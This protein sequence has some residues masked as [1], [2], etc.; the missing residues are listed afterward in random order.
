MIWV[1][2]WLCLFSVHCLYSFLLSAHHNHYCYCCCFCSTVTN[3]V[4]RMAVY[5]LKIFSYSLNRRILLC[6]LQFHHFFPYPN[7]AILDKTFSLFVIWQ[8]S[9]NWPRSIVLIWLNKWM[10]IK[11]LHELLPWKPPPAA[12]LQ[13]Q[14]G[15]Q[16]RR[17]PPTKKTIS[18]CARWHALS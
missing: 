12:Q 10:I 16:L 8:P 17:R 14:S 3:T 9:Q 7:Q 1:K 6:I 4:A 2:H 5:V 15:R 11:R 13:S 18:C